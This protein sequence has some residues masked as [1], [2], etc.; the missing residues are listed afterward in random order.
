MRR[1]K[2]A[3]IWENDRATAPRGRGASQ[4]PAGIVAHY[5]PTGPTTCARQRRGVSHAAIETTGLAVM[6]ALQPSDL[7]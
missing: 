7:L 4:V 2:P 3:A 6:L 5:G 1:G